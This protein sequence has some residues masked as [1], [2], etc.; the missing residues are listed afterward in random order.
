MA[1]KY[2]EYPSTVKFEGES[3][4]TFQ[5]TLKRPLS[6]T[7]KQMIDQAVGVYGYYAAKWQTPPKS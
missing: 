5:K 3:A 6:D 1:T 4:K 7:Q 2:K